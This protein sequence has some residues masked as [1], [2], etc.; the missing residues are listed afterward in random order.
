MTTLLLI[1]HATN[2]ALKNQLIVGRLPGVH[3]NEEGQA[4]A[5]AVAERLAEV[6]LTAVYSSPM[7]R[8]LETARPLAARHGLEVQIHPGLHEVDCGRWSGQP[9]ERLRRRRL[10]RTLVMC[11]S[12]IRFPGGENAWEVQTRMVAALE[13]IRVTHPGKTVAVVSHADPIKVAVAHYLGLPLDLFHRLKV[14]PASLTVLALDGA[15][16]QLVRLNDIGHL[17]CPQGRWGA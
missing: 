1:R 17:P 2:D 15:V 11:P 3:L 10:W 6:D 14:A 12:S 9:V 4:Q 7:E 8:A 16:P 5:L 13:E